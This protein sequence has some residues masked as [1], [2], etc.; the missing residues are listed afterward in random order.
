MTET[1]AA[2]AGSIPEFYERHLRSIFF[3][4]YAEDLAARAAI[5]AGPFLEMACGTGILTRHLLARLGEDA[6]LVSTDLNPPMLAEAQRRLPADPRLEWRQ[7]DM[8][9]LPFDDEAFG[10]VVCQFGFMFPPDKA[11]IFRE[12]RRVL[13]AGG[14]LLFN[15]WASLEENPANAAAL[16]ALEKLFPEDPPRFLEVPFGF[17][18]EARIRAFLRDHGFGNIHTEAIDMECRSPVARDFAIGLVRGT[19]LANDLQARGAV[20]GPVEDAIAAALAEMGGG[21]PFRCPMRALVVQAQA[22]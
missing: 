22:G 20:P 21:A 8:A 16:R 9:V 10:A 11:A 4:P 12:A 5:L 18:D 15:V 19:P 3:E 17:H 7:A 1:H 13:R 2:F 14:T 6:R